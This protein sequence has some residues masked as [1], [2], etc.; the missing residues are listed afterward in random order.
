MKTGVIKITH[1]ILVGIPEG[2]KPLGN[3]GLGERI[4]FKNILSKCDVWTGF[5]WLRI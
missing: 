2:K 1:T 3:L 5:M 4:I